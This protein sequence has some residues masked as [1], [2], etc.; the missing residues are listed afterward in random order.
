MGK[1][2][3]GGGEPPV[4]FVLSQNMHLLLPAHADLGMLTLSIPA[5]G[6]MI[7]IVLT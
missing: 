6:I 3:W 4:P 2:R 1:W 5:D 7:V